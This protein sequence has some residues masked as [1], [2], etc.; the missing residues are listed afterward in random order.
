MSKKFGKWVVKLHIPILIAAL[1][2]LIP[3]SIGYAHTKVNYGA[4]EG[5]LRYAHVSSEGY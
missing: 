4:Y 1:V 2:L 5:Q 3:A